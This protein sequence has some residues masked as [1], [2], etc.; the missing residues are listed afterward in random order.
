MTSIFDI[1]LIPFGYLMKLC[2]KICPKYVVA[3]LIFAIIT[4]IVLLPFGI[5][6]QKNS[7]KQASLQPK[8]RAI[9]RK[10]AGRT[11]RATQMKMNEEIQ[12]LYQKENF[13]PI[14]SCGPLLIQFPILIAVYNV[15]RS[16]LQY[17]Q[18]ISTDVIDQIELKFVELCN[19]GVLT[20]VSETIKNTVGKF[21]EETAAK[22]SLPQI[23]MVSAFRANPEIFR[24]HFLGFFEGTGI[25]SV[26]DLPDFTLFGLDLSQTPTFSLSWLILIPILTYVILYFSMKFTRKFTYQPEQTEDQKKSMRIMDVTMPLISVWVTFSVPAVV[27]IYWIYQNLLSTV[28]QV[29]LAKVMPM[30]RFTEEDFKEAEKAFSGSLSKK[31]KKKVRSLH[32]IDDEDDTF[33]SSPASETPRAESSVAPA[34]LKEDK[35]TKMTSASSGEKKIVRSLHHIDDDD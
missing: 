29:I 27:G 7:I 10:Y 28:Q 1:I 25:Q 6:Q 34:P 18:R 9:R 16:P 15:I 23:D 5:K 12:E 24:E 13:N 3:L 2:S 26:N 22:F 17:I 30:P 14:G 8:E 21:T 11:D 33:E 32:H 19:N 31:E 4:K 20:N 35:G